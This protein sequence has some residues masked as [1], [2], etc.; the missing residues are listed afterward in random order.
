MV[1]GCGKDAE[2]RPKKR[3]GRKSAAEKASQEAD[4]L[5]A[6]D[7]AHDVEAL[8]NA[9]SGLNQSDGDEIP[10]DEEEEEEAEEGTDEEGQEQGSQTSEGHHDKSDRGSS[11]LQH[12]NYPVASLKNFQQGNSENQPQLP[13]DQA[14]T[15]YSYTRAQ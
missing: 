5:K 9:E 3:R 1:K 10:G 15:G 6:G 7:G 12:H 8:G 14:Y 11:F 2:G 4:A 13:I